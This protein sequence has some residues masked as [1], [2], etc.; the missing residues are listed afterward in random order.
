[1]PFES[2]LPKNWDHE[3]EEAPL[4][5][6][7]EHSG[8]F[9]PQGDGEPFAILLPPP[10]ASEAIHI[11]N[12]MYTIQDILIRR[13]R[14]QGKRAFWIPGTDHAGFETQVVFEKKLEKEGKSRFDFDRQGFYDAV[15]AYTKDNQSTIIAQ[16]KS[17]GFSLDWS[18]L[19]FTL[20]P[21][22]V[23]AVKASFK[24]L[25]DDGL[26][27]RGERLV[28]Y[29]TKHQ[30]AFSDLEVE[31]TETE[32]LLWKL[33]YPLT[34]GSGEIIVATT[35]PETLFGDTAVAVHPD[36]TRYSS[37]VDKMVKLPLTERTI[38][39]IADQMVDPKFGT[40]AVKITPAHD[41]HDFEV[42]SRHDLPSIQVID[43]R[44]KLNDNAPE[45]YRGLK[46]KP[47]REQILAD[48]TA[49]GFLVGSSTHTSS[50]ATCYKCGTVIE[51]LPIPQWYL[52][53]RDADPAKNLAELGKEAVASGKITVVPERFQTV[54]LNWMDGLRDWNLSRQVWWGIPIPAWQC[55]QCHDWTVTAGDTP[56]RCNQCGSHEL[57]PD[58]DVFD[59][60]FSSSQLPY[61][62]L[63]E[64]GPE[65]LETFYPHAVMETGHDILTWW[66]A[67]MIYLGI[68][69]RGE[70]PFKAVYLHGMITD[71]QGKKMSK[72]KFNVIDPL[73]ITAKYGTDALRMALVV[74]NS[75][76]QSMAMYEEKIRGF[77]NFSNKIWNAGRF[78][79]TSL[80]AYAGPSFSEPSEAGQSAVADQ[81]LTSVTE[82]TTEANR[83]LDQ[84][85]IGQAG[86]FLY[87]Y[88]WHTFCDRFLEELKPA[89]QGS[90]TAAQQAL[91]YSLAQ[92]L[93]LLHPY[94]PYVTEALWQHLRQLDPQLS[95]LIM[96]ADW[97]TT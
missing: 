54:F 40:G 60:W 44:G 11:G 35:R 9:Q 70:V 74:G 68:Y 49:Q 33:R 63:E 34:D 93:K 58:P 7:W 8:G 27:Y 89:L 53:V 72:S 81:L 77:R 15:M 30:T 10:N 39:I 3:S 28:N 12:A 16:L 66:V 85:K 57:T 83:L 79:L 71:R 36:D 43:L 26:I 50:V 86:E 19:Y 84:W 14:M 91:G 2:L 67:R 87:D 23:D 41:L 69:L 92:L 73:T 95:E 29:C 21:K 46:V 61:A 31:H 45:A 90:D 82:A 42:A 56:P 47:A 88:F 48:L 37:I 24:R 22:I 55:A 76:G 18:H 78:V 94:V 59:T 20:D 52:K 6:K 75:P 65:F 13:A 62:V 64:F 97:P 32:G 38:P 80:E 25:H 96:V 4:Y 1:M 17:M 51:P 5:A